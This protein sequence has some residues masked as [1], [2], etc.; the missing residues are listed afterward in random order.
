MKNI[1][2][3]NTLLA[4]ILLIC[5]CLSYYYINLKSDILK[6]GLGFSQITDT[7]INLKLLNYNIE[8]LGLGIGL[9]LTIIIIA[10]YTIIEIKRH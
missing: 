4:F 1:I 5:S 9:I 6:E 3:K 7:L 2:L 8:L 10:Y